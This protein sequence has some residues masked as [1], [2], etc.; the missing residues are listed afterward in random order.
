MSTSRST[1][2]CAYDENYTSRSTKYCACHEICTSRPAKYCACYESCASKTAQYSA[3]HEICTSRSKVRRN[4][5][6][7]IN[8]IRKFKQISAAVGGSQLSAIS[9]IREESRKTSDH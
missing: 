1:K 4:E 8:K 6:Q 5:A 7:T 2:Y 9:L 3:C